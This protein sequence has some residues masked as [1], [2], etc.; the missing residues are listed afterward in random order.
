[1]DAMTTH[2]IT[3]ELPDP[4]YQSIRRLSRRSQRS[5]EAELLTLLESHTPAPGYGAY[6]AFDEVVDFLG[7]GAT[8][9]EIAAFKL[10]PAARA[11]ARELLAKNRAE[12][13]SEDET[14]ELDVYVELED[15][16]ALLKIRAHEQLQSGR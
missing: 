5:L 15:F 12:A 4:L 1:M 2:A 13:L 7:R 10:S 3:L 6:P 8:A 11:R 9:G 16:M 14:R